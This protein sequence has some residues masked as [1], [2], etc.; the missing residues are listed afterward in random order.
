MIDSGIERSSQVFIQEQDQT[1]TTNNER[2]VVAVSAPNPTAEVTMTVEV[3]KVKVVADLTNISAEAEAK[4]AEFLNSKAAIKELEA[5]QKAAEAA[6]R[7]MM[8]NADEAMIDGV[9]RLVIAHRSRPVVDTKMLND[10]FPEAAS[11]CTKTT[12]FTVLLTK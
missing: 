2:K 10:A 3:K 12:N 6:L 5:K 11:T 9:I 8:G 7:E 4:I 1:T